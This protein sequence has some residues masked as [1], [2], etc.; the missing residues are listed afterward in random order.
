MPSSS[1]TD[2]YSWPASRYSG[3]LQTGGCYDAVFPV[4]DETEKSSRTSDNVCFY[5]KAFPKTFPVDS[6][7][8]KCI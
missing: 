8:F 7:A 4:E 1:T 5:S 2:C 3:E 6:R